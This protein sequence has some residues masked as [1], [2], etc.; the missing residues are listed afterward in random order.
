MKQLK[1]EML[2]FYAN[3]PHN[4][5]V[6]TKIKPLNLVA[7]ITIY[8]C[9]GS[10]RHCPFWDITKCLK[11]LNLRFQKD[12]TFAFEMGQKIKTSKFSVIAYFCFCFNF[13]RKNPIS[14]K[15]Y[16]YYR[17]LGWASLPRPD[18]EKNARKSAF[19]KKIS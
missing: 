7:K 8:I 16:K 15:F 17:D 14:P 6:S 2:M 11:I 10:L 18:A 9:L 3:F 12:F 4:L 5:W 19:V 1:S 13:L